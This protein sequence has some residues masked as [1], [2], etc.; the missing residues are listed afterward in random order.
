M[1]TSSESKT[2]L[3]DALQAACHAMPLRVRAIDHAVAEHRK[4][5]LQI[6]EL[7]RQLEEKKNES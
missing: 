4:L 2:P 6:A 3:S 1:N 7:K 5:E